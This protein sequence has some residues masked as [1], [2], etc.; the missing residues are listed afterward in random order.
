[1][2]VTKTPSPA[3]RLVT[4][5]L[6]LMPKVFPAPEKLK[7]VLAK[8]DAAPA[9]LPSS[10][11]KLCTPQEVVEAGQ[12]VLTLTPRT[13]ASAWHIVYFHGGGFVLP[14][15]PFHWRMIG[16]LIES[17]GATVTLPFYGL[18]PEFDHRPAHALAET[19]LE[20]VRASHDGPIALAGDSAGANLALAATLNEGAAGRALP[21]R[22][23]LFSPWLD[24]TMSDPA[25]AEI[26]SSDVMLSAE[27]LRW[28][29]EAWAGPED[30]A[31][32]LLSPLFADLEGLPPMIVFQGDRDMFVVDARTFAE[33]VR[34][35]GAALDYFEYGGAPHD[36]MLFTFTREA[37]DVQRRVKDFLAG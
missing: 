12:R 5:A 22:L 16:K 14:M 23:I 37:K 31:G 7:P 6:G 30:A 33:K 2:L 18:A 34:Q 20:R 9:K 24:L 36:F 28:C 17:T 26:E 32:P 35:A 13:G 11:L 19:V 29:G 3:L 21:D 15:S 10:L 27:G 1:M 25:S 4:G 8:R